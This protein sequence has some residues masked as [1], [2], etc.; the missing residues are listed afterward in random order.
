MALGR[1]KRLIL[2]L[3][4]LLMFMLVAVPMLTQFQDPNNLLKHDGDL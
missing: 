3:L 1:R 4:A 2:L